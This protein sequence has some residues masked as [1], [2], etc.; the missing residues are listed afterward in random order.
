MKRHLAFLLSVLL[1]SCSAYALPLNGDFASGLSSWTS[2]GVVVQNEE[3]L[4]GEEEWSAYLYQVVPLSFGATTLEFD[5][6][7]G[8]SDYLPTQDPFAFLDSFFASLYFSNA[9]EFDLSSPP[10]TALSLL[11][12][13]VSGVNTLNGALSPSSK[14][15]GWQH[16]SLDFN[17]AYAYLIP[18]FELLDLNFEPGDSHVRVDN[19]VMTQAE[20]PEPSTLILLGS[21][22]LLFWPKRQR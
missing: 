14:G 21:G 17:N 4:L 11:D 20:I 13:D 10:P 15:D 7:S 8:L 12:L 19:V 1:F 6:L 9:A 5:F 18:V 2:G 3:A 16:F 22:L